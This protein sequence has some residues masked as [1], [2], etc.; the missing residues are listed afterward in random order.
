MSLHDT[1]FLLFG[2]AL[3]V[4]WFGTVLWCELNPRYILKDGDL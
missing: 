2:I 3:N 4:A 1:L